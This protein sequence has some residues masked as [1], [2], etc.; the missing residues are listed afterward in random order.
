MATLYKRKSRDQPRLLRKHSLPSEALSASS[1]FWRLFSQ[2]SWRPSFWVSLWLSSWAQPSF[3]P[4][5]WEL[6]EPQARVSRRELPLR[7]PRLRSPAPLLRFPPSPVSRRPA[8]R[9]PPAV[10]ARCHLRSFLSRNPFRPPLGE[11]LRAVVSR[12]GFL[13]FC[14]EFYK[15]TRSRAVVCYRTRCELSSGLRS[16]TIERQKSR[17]EAARRPF[18]HHSDG[19]SASL[20]SI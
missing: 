19:L 1:S 10:T 15:N 11:S 5:S 3:S 13:P 20:L 14:P 6:A 8:L 2:A 7:A 12:V 4:L 16:S 9:R 18:S 17:V